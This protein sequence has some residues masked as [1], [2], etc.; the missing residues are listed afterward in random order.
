MDLGHGARLEVLGY[1]P[2][3]L[4]QPFAPAAPGDRLTFPALAVELASPTTGVLP[5]QWVAPHGQQRTLRIGPGL[6][7][8][9]GRQARPEQ[10]AEFQNPPNKTKAGKHGTLVLGL[11]GSTFRW[12]V[13]SL[14]GKEPV[15]LGETGWSLRL[16]EYMPNYQEPG[17][18]LPN[19][20]G[21]SL[22][23]TRNGE[24][25]RVAL[26]ARHAGELYPMG[27]QAIPW[28]SLPGLWTWY[29]APDSRNG[30]SYLKAMLQLLTSADETIHYRSFSS[31]KTGEFAFEKAG[32][33]RKG[34]ARQRIWSGMGW[35]FQ[36]ADYLPQA[37]VG[38][39]FV[40][41][42]RRLGQEDLDTVPAIRCRLTQ[43]DAS[44]EFW[45][46]KSDDD[47]TP[48]RCGGEE[49]LIGYNSSQVTLEFAL[50]LLRAEQ[51]TDNGSALP[52]SQTSFVLLTDPGKRLYNQG[53]I[54]TLNQPL[55]HRGYKFYQSGFK[56]LGVDASGKPINR[57]ML[58]VQYDPGLWLKYAGS[59]ML[60]LG[61][62]CMFYMKA[63][64]FKYLKPAF[65]REIGKPTVAETPTSA[66]LR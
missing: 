64:F 22:E 20:P 46:G 23:L 10:I 37:A 33:A 36:I 49:F 18:T 17:S 24:K 15:P 29:H 63:Y 44:Q 4:Q 26:T 27:K 41:V 59:T 21:L 60:A 61:I 40:P 6:V 57:S 56:S 9:L 25:V 54:I 8:F 14:A 5:V 38:P 42:E 7:E 34:E 13:E 58:T 51:V 12:D 66:A 50:R 52:A 45:L 28:Q 11:A 47:F 43:G 3:A 53:R 55:S 16:A 62:A 39:H 30:D 2:H 31:A 32:I 48:V 1:F 35:K 65:R 19:D